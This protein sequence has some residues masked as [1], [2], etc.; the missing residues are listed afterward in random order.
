MY[1]V[2]HSGYYNDYLYLTLI[3]TINGLIIIFLS[4]NDN[5]YYIFFFLKSF[6][7]DYEIII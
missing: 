2:T 1:Y 7:L 3:F 4:I 6:I 5:K